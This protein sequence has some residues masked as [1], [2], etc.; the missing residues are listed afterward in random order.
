M[1]EAGRYDLATDLV[2]RLLSAQTKVL[3]E[4]GQFFQFYHSDEAIGLG[5]AEHLGGVVPV[6]LL[7]RVLG[8]RVISG[9]KVW[10]GGLYHWPSA[11]TV[12][13]HGMTVQRSSAGTHITFASGKTAQLAADAEWQEV[14]D[15][16][17]VS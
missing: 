13:Q 5:M 9:S 2:R 1:I 12:R 17:N 14:I 6:Y 11:V 15:A 16:E 7:L 8:V 3:H 10:T 4:Q